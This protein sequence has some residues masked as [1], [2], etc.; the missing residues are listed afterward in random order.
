MTGD[1]HVFKELLISVD[2]LASLLFLHRTDG[3]CWRMDN[4]AKKT[5]VPGKFSYTSEC[6]LHTHTQFV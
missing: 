5:D 2:T 6:D 4:L 1:G 3:T